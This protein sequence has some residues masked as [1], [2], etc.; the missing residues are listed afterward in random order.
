MKYEQEIEIFVLAFIDTS[1]LGFVYWE[2]MYEDN[3]KRNTA[4]AYTS[5]KVQIFIAVCR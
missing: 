5:A 2:V 4:N 1:S 3:D